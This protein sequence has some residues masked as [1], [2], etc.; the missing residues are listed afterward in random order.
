MQRLKAILIAA[1]CGAVIGALVSGFHHHGIRQIPF[2]AFDRILLSH[3]RYWN[4]GVIGWV[5]FSLYWEAAAKNAAPAKFGVSRI[6][7][8]PRLSDQRS[9]DPDSRPDSWAGP[10]PASRAS[11]YDRGPGG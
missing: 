7:L 2:F 9:L 11:D 5:L 3:K 10:I 1:L 6:P 4:A 8:G